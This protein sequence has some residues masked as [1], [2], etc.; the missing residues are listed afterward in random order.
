[1][2]VVGRHLMFQSYRSFNFPTQFRETGKCS[3]N[4][5]GLSI[6]LK[7]SAFSKD[8]IVQKNEGL[9]IIRGPVSTIAQN[10]TVTKANEFSSKIK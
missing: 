3:I 6:F 2:N 8:S 1:V 5:Q 9:T 4:R 10:R 7:K